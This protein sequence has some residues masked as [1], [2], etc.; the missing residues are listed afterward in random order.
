MIASMVPMISQLAT[1]FGDTML[2]RAQNKESQRWSEKM[3]QRQY[4]DNVRFWNQQNE[5]NTPEMQMQRFKGAGLNPNLI[6][7]QGSSGE[8]GPIKSPEVQK[9]NFNYTPQRALSEA[10][11]NPL[12]FALE[13]ET[14]ELT[15][16]NLRADNQ[17]KLEDAILR[18][19]QT[20][21]TLTDEE[22][23]RFDLEFEKGLSGISSDTRKE[24]LRQLKTGTDLSINRDAREAAVVS[25]S[26]KEAIQRMSESR[27]RVAQ[28]KIESQRIRAST[29]L[30]LN[31]AELRQLEIELRKDGINPNDPTWLVAVARI[32]STIAESQFEK[33]QGAGLIEWLLK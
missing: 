19:A 31:D 27:Q 12:Q 6:Y 33:P 22:R 3:Y 29:Q 26:L 11:G 5:Y 4:D 18:R 13:M 2:E 32:L 7:G 30:L 10:A 15:N 17:I 23:K 14:R 20:R 25:S 28:S 16:D 24:K 21:A 1:G 9:P 8:A